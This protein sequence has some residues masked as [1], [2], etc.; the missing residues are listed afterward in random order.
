MFCICTLSYC[1]FGSWEIVWKRITDLMP[2]LYSE[3]KLI[4]VK[5]HKQ[6]QYKVTLGK[7]RQ[8]TTDKQFSQCYDRVHAVL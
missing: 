2:R 8:I 4:I 5:P 3:Q 7:C 6:M 1:F